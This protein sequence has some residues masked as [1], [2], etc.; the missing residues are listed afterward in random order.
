MLGYIYDPAMATLGY[1]T[2]GGEVAGSERLFQHYN[3]K[4]PTQ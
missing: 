2:A 4:M 3:D 1:G